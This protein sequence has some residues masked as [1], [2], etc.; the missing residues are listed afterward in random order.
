MAT[1]F[2]E[3]LSILNRVL[4]T[5]FEPEYFDN[6]YPFCQNGTQADFT[7]AQKLLG[8]EPQYSLAEGIADYFEQMD[9]CGK[10]KI[11]KNARI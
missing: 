7:E 11:N 1:S 10:A 8:F 9:T 2:N 6:P 3:V 5:S 4:G